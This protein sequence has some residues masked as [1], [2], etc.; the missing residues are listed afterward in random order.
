MSAMDMEMTAPPKPTAEEFLRHF[1]ESY[2][3]CRKKYSDQEWESL[4][5][6]NEKWHSTGKWNW[7]MLWTTNRPLDLKDD[8]VLKKVADKLDVEYWER[9]PL[10]LDGA[11]Y[12]KGARVEWVFLSRCWW[13]L[14]MRMSTEHL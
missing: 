11:F 9:E 2:N 14:S 12:P 6:S 3:E 4:W 10:N 8:S 1:L 13:P 7:F 5:H